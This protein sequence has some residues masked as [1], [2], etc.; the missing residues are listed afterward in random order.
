M[1][2][3]CEREL[4]IYLRYS[5]ALRIAS[6]SNEVQ[7]YA[8][9]PPA[10]TTTL[11]THHRRK[12]RVGRAGAPDAPAPANQ[13]GEEIHFDDVVT[14][15]LAG[16][17]DLPKEPQQEHAAAEQSSAPSQGTS[18]SYAELMQELEGM[19][20]GITV[21]DLVAGLNQAYQE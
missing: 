13:A 3:R 6:H 1:K 16:T 8:P 7:V 4:T 9:I 19:G 11:A 14:E 15:I 5:S 12:P 17:W 20:G 18:R 2:P 10:P 21:D